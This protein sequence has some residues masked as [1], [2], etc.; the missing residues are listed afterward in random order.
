MPTRRNFFGL[1]AAAN[2]R[3]F[4]AAGDGRRLD[5]AAIQ[6]TIDACAAKGGGTVLFPPGRYVSGTL[7]L[8]SRVTLLLESGAVLEGSRNL[9]DYPVTVQKIRSF[10]DIYTNKSLIYAEDC[11]DIGIEGRGV[12]DGQGAAFTGPF[13]VRPF[14][15]RMIACRNVSIQD[16]SLKDS[17]MWTQHYLAC[18]GV[19]IRG[20]KVRG[21]L[22]HQNND[23]IDIDSCT[24]VRIADCDIETGDD[25]IVLKSTTMRPCRNVAVTNCVLSSVASAIKTGTES[26]GAFE[27]IVVSNCTIYDTKGAGIALISVDG[28]TLDRVAVSGIVMDNVAAPI[29]VRLGDR[30]RPVQE[31]GPRPPVGRLR[32]VSIRD[33]IAARGHPIGCSI[34]GLPGHPVE[35]LVLDNVRMEFPGGGTSQD[36]AR[37]IPENADKYPNFPMLGML[38]SYG[39]YCRHVRG[40]SLRHVTARTTAPDARP[41]LVCDD[42]EDLEL[43]GWT[44]SE[45]GLKRVK[46]LRRS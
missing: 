37:E 19:N 34:T 41:A 24:L 4:G 44:G 42:V 39:L 25:C 35:N 1:L 30:G 9:A 6:K 18:D 32:N 29:F 10:T 45:P 40:L 11:E 33:V 23:G 12:I 5:T 36:A 28:G 15:I 8:K 21:S 31:G 43:Q 14:L 26:N 46:G 27:N 17:P 7:F 13:L 2:I 38:P 22:P 3:D 16:V 20:I